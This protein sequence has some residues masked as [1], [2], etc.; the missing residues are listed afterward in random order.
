MSILAV[1]TAAL[2]I[3]T[4]VA[5]GLLGL[6]LGTMRTLRETNG[7]LRDRVSDLEKTR[8]EDRA[9][10]AELTSDKAALARVVTG[11][12]HMVAFGDQLTHFGHTL[13]QHDRAAKSHWEVD[14]ALLGEIRDEL[15][16]LLGGNQR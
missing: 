13:E 1:L 16:E 8:T 6:Q 9:Q 15:R 7:D 3:A 5:S 2:G 10:I 11:E 12:A 14:E 4:A